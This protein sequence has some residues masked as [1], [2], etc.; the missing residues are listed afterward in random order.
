MAQYNN[1]THTREEWEFD[2]NSILFKGGLIVIFMF[3]YGLKIR[4]RGSSQQRNLQLIQKLS[5]KIVQ[6]L[7]TSMNWCAHLQDFE[8]TD[9]KKPVLNAKVIPYENKLTT[10]VEKK[11]MDKHPWDIAHEILKEQE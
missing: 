7:N 1:S 8:E 10:R 11:K 5:G 4:L 6:L 3:L 2:H 9:V